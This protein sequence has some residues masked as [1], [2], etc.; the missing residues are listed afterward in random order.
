MQQIERYGVIAL[1]LLLVTVLAVSMWGDD[2]VQEPD[3]RP[4][5][6]SAP[7]TRRANEK[8]IENA[9]RR[10][11]RRDERRQ[12]TSQASSR[13]DSGPPLTKTRRPEDLVQQ[14]RNPNQGANGT[15]PRNTVQDTRKKKAT[16]P[17][18][19]NQPGPSPHAMASPQE[20][21]AAHRTNAP[22]DPLTHLTEWKPDRNKVV[23]KESNKVRAED[24]DRDRG[25]NAKPA[26]NPRSGKSW[27][28]KKGETLSGIASKALGSAQRWREIAK[29]NPKVDPDRLH[30]GVKLVL[31]T[32]AAPESSTL[33]PAV[34]EA[35]AKTQR[36]RSSGGKYVIQKGDMLSLIAQRELGS[37]ARWREIAKLNPKVNPDKLLVGTSLILPSGAPASKPTR[38]SEPKLAAASSRPSKR[39]RVR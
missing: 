23:E 11:P 9:K 33:Q 29:L 2:S 1:L 35:P 19:Q 36:A 22:K 14:K 34:A 5:L 27:T 37:A 3:S 31:P 6:A 39:S 12:S 32:G 24:L 25:R 18:P 28:V 8:A 21:F 17:P 10:A 16:M 38:S 26:T 4:T 15:R 20:R 13:L 30:V 7:E